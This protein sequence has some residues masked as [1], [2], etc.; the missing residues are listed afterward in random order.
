M[1]RGLV[2]MA[3]IAT[4]APGCGHSVLIARDDLTYR[5]AIAHYRRTRQ[6]IAQSLAPDDDQAMFLQAEAMFRYRFAA[7]SRS[8]GSYLAQIAASLIDLPALEAFA[9]A[10][11]LY[12]LR[13]RMNDG[14]VQL[15]ETL[16]AF[17]PSTPLRSL[18]LYR[19]GWAYRDTSAT[20][21]PRTSDRAFDELIAKDA[22]S[23]L[24]TL[25][26][27]ARRVPWKSPST[28]TAWSIIPGAGEIYARHYGSGVIH[29]GVAI[30]AATAVLVP[31]AIAY[32]RRN[33][34]SWGHDWPLLLSGVV[35]ASVLTLD[36]SSSYDNA[37][38]DAVLFNEQ[39]EAAFEHA[40]PDAP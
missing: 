7:P 15:W 28:A 1:L 24:A 2:L 19:L 12:S 21:F 27:Q 8:A 36:Y 25:A 30:A 10:L 17:H 14:A 31:I 38:R 20:G 37:V 26:G 23:P 18:T 34:L 13:L 22:G 5:D 33:D 40:H 11:D 35:G 4:L 32:E 3:A 6:L 29:L 39:Q 9:G 16:L